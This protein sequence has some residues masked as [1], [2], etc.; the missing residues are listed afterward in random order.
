MRW[1]GVALGGV[2]A[3]CA[4]AEWREVDQA[5]YRVAAP[6]R[7][8]SFAPLA[9]PHNTFGSFSEAGLTAWHVH[10][11]PGARYAFVAACSRECVSLDMQVTASDG[12]TARGSGTGRAAVIEPDP[13]VSGAVRVEIR[14]GACRTGRCY[15][16]AQL[17][18]AR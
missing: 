1:W 15:W 16:A 14:H 6:L 13:G 18:R 5:M 4:S 10:L 8:R 3:A 12:S 2:V 11:Q 17:L 7:A 9:G